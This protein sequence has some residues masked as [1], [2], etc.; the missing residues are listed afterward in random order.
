MC[1]SIY[2]PIAC[3]LV[4]LVYKCVI[5]RIWTW[6]H[7]YEDAP[8]CVKHWILCMYICKH[9]CVYECQYTYILV[10]ARCDAGVGDRPAG[11]T[12]RCST[13]LQ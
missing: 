11:S 7:M 3:V 10:P 6:V 5:V 8:T 13:S 4:V 2:E 12:A 9:A 1:L